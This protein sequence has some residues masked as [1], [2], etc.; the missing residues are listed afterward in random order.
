[1]IGLSEAFFAVGACVI[2]VTPRTAATFNWVGGDLSNPFR[3]CVLI[4]TALNIFRNVFFEDRRFPETM[5]AATESGTIVY[6]VLT[7]IESFGHT[8]LMLLMPYLL[9]CRLS[10]VINI[11]PGQDLVPWLKAILF[12]HVVGVLSARFN[13]NMW[14][15]KRFGDALGCVP[16]IKTLR[17][18]RRVY[19]SRGGNNI[20]IKSLEALEFY[21]L[22]ITIAAAV[23]YFFDSRRS[24]VGQAVRVASIF[25]SE[26]RVIF[27]G[28]LLNI[29]DEASHVPMPENEGTDEEVD[30]SHDDLG[31]HRMLVAKK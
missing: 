10:D 12:L 23:G 15:I 6:Y 14:A 20:I 22:A 24:T 5:V 9:Q 1:M 25:V 2:V 16:V 17:T 27:H 11:K 21:S 26:T 7:S 28:L 18:F 4:S 31:E 29:T 19:S 13:P 30:G 8:V 3:I